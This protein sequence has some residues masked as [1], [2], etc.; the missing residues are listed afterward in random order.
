MKAFVRSQQMV[1]IASST[2]LNVNHT[3]ATYF[4]S[5]Y[6]L[7]KHIDFPLLYTREAHQPMHAASTQVFKLQQNIGFFLIFWCYSRETRKCDF[8]AHILNVIGGK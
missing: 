4:L 2:S 5:N 7:A 3:R 6:N 8:Q 1:I